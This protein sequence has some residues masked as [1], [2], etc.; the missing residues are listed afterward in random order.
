LQ[1]EDKIFIFGGEF[2]DN[3]GDKMTTFNDLYTYTPSHNA[4]AKLQVPK[5]YVCPC[6]AA[7]S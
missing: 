7:Q 6:V 4:W 2:Y 3:N 1:K 5:G